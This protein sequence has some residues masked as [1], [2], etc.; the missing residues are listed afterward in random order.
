MKLNHLAFI[1][2]FTTDV[3]HISGANNIIAD[4]L[5]R[6]DAV[7][8]PPIT[9]EDVARA[10]AEDS[11]LKSLL[12]GRTSLQLERV[13][14]PGSSTTMY[15][16]LSTRRPRPYVPATHRRAVFDALHNLSDPGTRATS[17]LVSERNVWSHIQH[18]CRARARTCLPCHRAKIHR[19]VSSPLMKLAPSSASSSATAKFSRCRS[20]AGR[21]ASAWIALYRRTS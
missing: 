1:A 6:V 14:I 20:T 8:A 10:Q 13:P 19:H 16:D 4:T 2:Q 12:D 11:E 21:C 15:C 17:R 7:A 18:D 9:A 3:R 5:S